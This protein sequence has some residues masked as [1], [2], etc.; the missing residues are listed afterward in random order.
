[1]FVEI[2]GEGKARKYYLVHSYRRG[3]RVRKLRTYLGANLGKD[4]LELKRQLAET[5]F[6]EFIEQWGVIRDPFKTIL[7]P[8]EVEELRALQARGMPKVLRLTEDQWKSFSEAF[9]YDTNAIEGS[10]VSS[11]EVTAILERGTWPDKP[12]AEISETYGVAR[13][14]EFMRRTE[15]VVSIPLML[16]FHRLVFENSMP[17][18]GK[19]RREGIEVVVADGAGRIVHRG[20]PSRHVRQLLGELVGWYGKNRA[21]Y[22]PLVLAAVVHNQFEHIHP[23]EDG[24][25]R[26]GRLLMNN[27]LIKNGLPPINIELKNRNEYYAT[28]QAYEKEHDLRPTIELMLKEYRALKRV[29]GDYPRKKRILK[30]ERFYRLSK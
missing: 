11:G 18:A 27:V 28:L 19:F 23:F 14:V 5:K 3:G 13:A 6:R 1:M 16:E 2:R 22:P 17:F 8:A 21:R 4:A 12:K 25:G 30:K 9:T 24:N 20:A 29:V 10:T 15:D 26:V 7:K